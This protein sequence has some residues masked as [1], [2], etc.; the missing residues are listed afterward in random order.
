M[1]HLLLWCSLELITRSSAGPQKSAGLLAKRPPS[2]FPLEP[3]SPAYY[4]K[5]V[6]WI[7]AFSAAKELSNFSL[8]IDLYD[9]A[10]R[11]K[12]MRGDCPGAKE[13]KQSSCEDG[14]TLA[15]EC[16][17]V[18]D[19]LDKKMNDK[20][21]QACPKGFMALKCCICY[22]KEK[23]VDEVRKAG[24][25][26]HKANLD[27]KNRIKRLMDCMRALMKHKQGLLQAFQEDA[28]ELD[29]EVQAQL[30]EVVQAARDI[31]TSAGVSSL[32]NVANSLLTSTD[33]LSGSSFGQSKMTA[34]VSAEAR[35][36]AEQRALAKMSTHRSRILMALQTMA[37]SGRDECQD[38][39]QWVEGGTNGPPGGLSMSLEDAGIKVQSLSDA[40]KEADK[41]LPKSS[42]V[43]SLIEKTS[44]IMQGLSAGEQT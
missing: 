34:E 37:G 18:P 13:C 38:A 42:V 29:Q 5:P 12:V 33:K 3:T 9:D 41:P 19:N 39:L 10:D 44:D 26:S 6:S 20:Q 7:Q 14:Q 30:N 2:E 43:H 1:Y 31:K 24:L 35:I 28:F 16:E 32:I 21:K 17:A 25:N 15:I 36:T 22:I 40:E 23:K 27:Y 8:D 4:G 11:G